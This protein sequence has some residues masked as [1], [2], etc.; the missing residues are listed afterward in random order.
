MLGDDTFAIRFA[1]EDEVGR[2]GMG[3]VHRAIERES[4]QPVAIKIL[5]ATAHQARFVLEAETL[6]RLAHPAIVAYVGHGVTRDGDAYLAMAWIDGESLAQRLDRGPLSIADTL[7]A[8]IRIAGALAHAHA[9]GIVHRDIKP[10]NVMLVDQDPRRATLIDFGIAKD[11]ASTQN[12]TE[13]GQL[14]G[15]PGYMSPEQAMGAPSLDARTDMFAFGALLYHC[16]TGTPPF[17]GKQPMEVLALLLLREPPPVRDLVP[18]IPV[19]LSSLIGALLVKEPEKRLANAVAVEAELQAIS[20]AIAGADTATLAAVSPLHVERG[21]ATTAQTKIERPQPRPRRRRRAVWLF[22]AAVVLIGAGALAL[23][24]MSNDPAPTV[25]ET[26]AL[27]CE[28]EGGDACTRRC[29]QNDPDACR[30]GGRNLHTQAKDDAQ[31]RFAI[32]HLLER[33]CMLADARSCSLQALLIRRRLLRG[34]KR[35]T[36]EQWVTK[37]ELGCTFGDESACFVL[38]GRMLEDA[39]SQPVRA[40]ELYQRGCHMNHGLS[41]RLAAEMVGRR[42]EP[43]D[44]ARAAALLAAACRNGDT[45][46]CR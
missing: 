21:N 43:G 26:R 7:A 11:T 9:A 4:K 29:E 10:S 37:Y 16:L 25:A 12:L 41:C 20:D 3:S 45:R 35:Y 2:G 33:G 15:T 39:P 38:G 1:I 19:R 17:D 36:R 22:P 6:E 32:D 18:D 40:L 8:G 13:T 14:V 23:S 42:D 27:P 24:M 28:R 44:P 46:S 30:E 31:Q 34:D 5:H